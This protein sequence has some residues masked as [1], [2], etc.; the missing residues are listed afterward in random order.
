MVSAPS[1]KAQTETILYSF[2]G[3]SGDAANPYGGLAMDTAGNLYGTSVNGGAS[4]NC[5]A[6]CG[7][8]F[9]LDSSGNET[10][11]YSFTGSSGDGAHPY[12]G[13]LIDAA[14]N[15]YG[16]TFNG[17]TSG[18]GTVFELVNTGAYTEQVLYSFGGGTDGANPYAGLVMDSSGNLYGTTAGGAVSTN[19]PAVSPGVG[20]PPAPS[21]TG[22]GTV[23]K[24]APGSAGLWT[25]TILHSFTGEPDGANPCAGLLMD[26]SGN[27]YG[28]TMFGGQGGPSGIGQGTAFKLD[29]SGNETILRDFGGLAERPAQTFDGVYPYAGLVMDAM[30]NLYGATSVTG[31]ILN[32]PGGPGSVFELTPSSNGTYLETILYSFGSTGGDQGTSGPHGTLVLDASG[33]LYGT[34]SGLPGLPFGTVFKLAPS[35]FPAFWTETTLQGFG[36]TAQGDG[37]SPYAGLLMDASGNL[38]GTTSVGG[39]AGDGTVFKITSNNTQGATTITLASSS[40]PATAGNSVNLMATVTSSSGTPTGT[41]TFSNGS[42][43]LGTQTLSGGSTTLSIAD[44]ESLGVGTYTITA[45]YTPSAGSGFAAGSGSVSQTINEPGVALTG[46]GNNF[47]GNQTVAGSLTATS[48]SGNGAGL[49]NLNPAALTS[50]IAGINITGNAATATT[51]LSAT[52]ATSLAF[53]PTLCGTNLFSIGIA[54]N[55]NANCLQPASTNLSDYSTLVLNNRSN[56]F[57]GGKQTLPAS[58]A[59][60]ASLNLPNSGVAPSTPAIGDVWLTTADAHPKFQ[61]RT[62]TAQSLAFLSDVSSTSLL[63]SNNTFTGTNTFSQIIKG[64]INGNAAT[65]TSAMTATSATTATSAVTATTAGSATTAGALGAT[66]AQCGAGMFATGIAANG[67]A[68]CATASTGIASSQI[69]FSS[70]GVGVSNGTFLGIAAANHA[71]ANVGQIIALSG[72]VIAMQC[73][74][75]MAPKYG[76]ETFTLRLN[77]ANTA[78][79]CTISAG[80]TKGSVTGLDLA[81]AAGNLLDLEV[82]GPN[83]LGAATVAVAVGP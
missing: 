54:A 16:T 75:Q 40:N 81:I 7:A 18:R 58:A 45:Q 11:L 71:E 22:C 31:P 5:P 82:G 74:S 41:V 80:S 48:L 28:T 67:N 20:P 39:T 34:T 38:Y 33:N 19:C 15:L 12:A 13:L 65:A 6:G 73:F 25:E 77:G 46:S 1:A 60:Y 72:H 17:G 14:G 21:L 23:F 50:G 37:A 64:S 43:V 32:T 27:L 78:G 2:T 55:G 51:A 61:D 24:L 57:A 42:T 49:T 10:I 69:L 8:V 59:G 53:A 68:N 26:A 3:S 66:P 79:V 56:T 83:G 70:A 76:S 47:I 63:S 36:G 35:A 44:A 52:I 30:G 29:S 9:K 62:G 4:T